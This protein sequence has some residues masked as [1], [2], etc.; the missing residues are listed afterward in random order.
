VVF[1]QYLAAMAVVQGVK[2]YDSSNRTIT[3]SSKSRYA[4]IPVK[5]K[6]PNDIY[7]LSP[8]RSDTSNPDAY[9][10][11]GGILVNSHYNAESYI[12]VCGIGL[13]V[14]NPAPTT[15]LNAL[16]ASIPPGSSSTHQRPAPFTLERLLARI[17]VCFETLYTRFLDTGFDGYFEDLYYKDWL[18]M[19]QI[20]TLETQGGARAR[21]KGITRDYGLL[22]AAE[23]GW[24]DR[25]TGRRWELQSD[26]NSFDFVSFPLPRLFALFRN[27]A[28]GYHG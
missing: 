14:S 13:N 20:V 18:H 23:L 10:K 25:S 3:H 22:V 8:G 7:A 28:P 12:A 19:D 4:D 26:S 21:I 2:T 15:S 24:E 16:L 17:L 9:T 5:L 11:I 1:V 6:W 27:M